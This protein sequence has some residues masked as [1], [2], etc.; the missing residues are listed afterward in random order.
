MLAALL[1]AATVAGGLVSLLGRYWSS[2]IGEGLIY[3]LRTQLY[4]HVQRMPLAFFTRTQTGALISPHEQRRDRRAAGGHRHARH[5]LS[6]VVTLV[7]TLDR[8]VCS[9]AVTLL[10][11]LVVPIFIVPAKR[12][13]RSCRRSP[14]SGMGLNAEMNTQMT[15]RFNVAGAQLVKLFGRHEPRP[16]RSRDRA[17]AVRDIGV[18]SAM[19]AARSSSA[20]AWSAPSAPPPS[21][22]SAASL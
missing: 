10:A 20:S 17:G 21:T 2:R 18:R 11:L 12:V 9:V 13:G 15:E 19:T 4:D 6:N 22:G 1:V 14:A 5:G 7:T 16:R 3:D 8:H